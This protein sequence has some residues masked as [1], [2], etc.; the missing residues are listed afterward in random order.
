MR[1]STVRRALMGA[2]LSGGLKPAATEGYVAPVEDYVSNAPYIKITPEEQN[3]AVQVSL[4][5]GPEVKESFQKAHDALANIPHVERNNV[6]IRDSVAHIDIDCADSY[7]PPVDSVKIQ[8]SGPYGQSI[9]AAGGFRRGELAVIAE[10]AEKVI[11][12]AIGNTLAAG[13][14]KV[15]RQ[16]NL[17]NVQTRLNKSKAAKKK[18]KTSSLMKLLIKQ[19]T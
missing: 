13:G 15:V 8:Q 12:T 9:A 19:V 17:R 18:V 11:K 2:M 6:S 7:K 10:N 4:H 14:S 16:A 1:N 5:L 3:A